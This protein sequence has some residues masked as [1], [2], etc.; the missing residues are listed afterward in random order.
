MARQSDDRLPVWWRHEPRQV[1]GVVRSLELRSSAELPFYLSDVPM[2]ILIADLELE[3]KRLRAHDLLDKLP[4]LEFSIGTGPAQCHVDAA[5]V[6]IYDR[7]VSLEEISLCPA[8]AN[9]GTLVLEVD[10][11]DVSRD[12]LPEMNR[13]LRK[14]MTDAARLRPYQLRG[15]LL[16]K[17]AL[18]AAAAI[19]K[20]RQIIKKRGQ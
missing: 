3:G 8:G 6:N 18:V 10:G 17:Y 4:H 9:K 5:G 11:Q 12:F 16:P 14:A 19:V 15:E 2:P 7:G 1:L 20:A 13:E